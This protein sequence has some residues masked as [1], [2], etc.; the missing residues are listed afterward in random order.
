M[1]EIVSVNGVGLYVEEYGAEH[2][3]ALLYLHGGPSASCMDFSYH[4]ARALAAHIH[5]VAIDQRGVLRSEP[6]QA[7]APFRLLD[8]LGDFEALRR[9]LGIERW[10]VLGHS[11]GGRLA[12]L[13][14]HH[15]PT[16]VNRVI[17][18]TPGWNN[19]LSMRSIAR[20]AAD[21]FAAEGRPE[22]LAACEAL[23]AAA[24]QGRRAWDLSMAM[25]ELLG[26]ENKNRMYLHGMTPAALDAIYAS[27][28][29]PLDLYA[30]NGLYLERLLA[31]EATFED[32]LPLLDGNP[33]PALLIR[34]R[35]DPVCD[36]VQAA[37]FAGHAPDGRTV[38]FEHSAHFPR[39]EEP[40]AYNRT[41]L[42]FVLG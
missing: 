35:Y 33:Q 6:L 17:Y 30:R 4:Q 36:D 12:C 27:Y 24:D 32:V 14:A 11:F 22:G 28:Q 13:Y 38:T 8:N 40:E 29:I 10:A 21:T 42:D 41:V 5:V 23:M 1:G 34:G 3:R 37:Y 31:D 39:L 2:P 20:R 7:D 25:F 16:A 18:E 19:G 26:P 15:Y 9:H